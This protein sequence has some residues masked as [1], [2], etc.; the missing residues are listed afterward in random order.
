MSKSSYNIAVIIAG[1]DEEYQS[2]ILSGIEE[3]KSRNRVNIAVFVSFS[4][5]MG[6]QRHDVGEFNIFNLPDFKLFDG[7]ILLTNTIG[8]QPV[9]NDIFARIRKAGIPTVS[10]DYDVKDFYHIGIDN[11]RAMRDITEHIIHKHGCRTFNYVSGPKDNPESKERYESFLEVLKENN[12]SIEKERI[13]FGDFRSPSGREAVNA[14]VESGKPMPEAIVCAND[15]MAISAMIALNALGYRIPED[16]IVSGFDNTYRAHNYPTELTS[17]ER[18]LHRSGKLA[19]EI[20]FNHFNNIPQERSTILDMHPHF[21]ESCGCADCSETATDVK[22]L[23]NINYKKFSK[24]ESTTQY[25]SL[26]NRM[27]SQL[28]ECDSLFEFTRSLKPFIS[29]IKPELFCMCICSDWNIE[30]E[31][32]HGSAAPVTVNGYTKDILVPLSY[33]YGRFSSLPPFASADIL[34]GLFDA[35]PKGR[36]YYFIP[37]HFRERALGYIVIMNSRFPLQ[38]SMFQTWCITMSNMLENVRKIISLDLA[39]QKL[40]KLY[41]VDTLTGIFNRNG[42]VNNATP[43]FEQCIKNHR[44]VMLMFIDMDGL[45]LINDNYGHDAGDNAIRTIANII[46]D[47]CVNSEVYCRFGGDEFIIFGAGFSSDEAQNLTQKIN[48][49]TEFYNQRNDVP[50]TIAASIGFHI[51]YPDEGDDLFNLVTIADNIMYKAKK[52]KKLSKYLKT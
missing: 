14:F 12:I 18:P 6:N 25:M 19:C 35:T 33:K 50:Y 41:T 27:S 7:A 28:V 43:Q 24:F 40:N 37:L 48:A 47:S 34:P 2:E 8:Y 13:Y 29:E 9:I 45:K 36:M 23:K 42:F 5:V 4:G 16:I 51:A 26:V 30:A 20:L 10:V 39:V 3:F 11:G 22:A 46:E 32:S 49:N 52:K 44:P 38:S 31:T 1:I 17:V 15:D 21:T